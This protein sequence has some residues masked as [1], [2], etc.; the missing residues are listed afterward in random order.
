MLEKKGEEFLMNKF[1]CHESENPDRIQDFLFPSPIFSPSGHRFLQ[2]TKPWPQSWA[3]HKSTCDTCPWVQ[4]EFPLP[5]FP[6]SVVVSVGL[7]AVAPLMPPAALLPA[8]GVAER[9]A[10]WGCYQGIITRKGCAQLLSSSWWETVWAA[11]FTLAQR[12]IYP[13]FLC[14]SMTIPPLSSSQSC[15]PAYYVR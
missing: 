10:S 9:L 3:R 11:V 13:Q 4:E 2:I 5:R 7:L 6:N 14:A 1:V 12:G 15:T 8:G